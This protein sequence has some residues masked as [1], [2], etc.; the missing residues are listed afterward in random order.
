MGLHLIPFAAGMAIGAIATYGSRDASVQKQFKTGAH[1][2]TEGTEWLYGSVVTGVK[3]L[4]GQ[5]PVTEKPVPKGR[6]RKARA[7]A[8]KGPAK[9][10]ATK[11]TRAK[12][13][14][15]TTKRS[16]TRARKTA[17]AAAA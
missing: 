3:S 1:Y 10:G 5:S 16:T 7:S 6:T 14:T 11:R 13:T 2:I 9:A 17:Q 12:A 15:T 8:K 4:F